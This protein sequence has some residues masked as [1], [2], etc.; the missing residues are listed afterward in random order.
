L[1]DTEQRLGFRIPWPIWLIAGV[2]LLVI[3]ALFQHDPLAIGGPVILGVICL[4]AA[5]RVFVASRHSHPSEGSS[6]PA[7]QP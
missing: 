3:G 1:V 2:V 4:I 5:V 7:G 6:S